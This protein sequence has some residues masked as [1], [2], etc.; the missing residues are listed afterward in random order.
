MRANKMEPESAHFWFQSLSLVVARTA[1]SY[2][3]PHGGLLHSPARRPPTFARMAASYV[4]IQRCP[5]LKF[6]TSLAPPWTAQ[7]LF[8]EFLCEWTN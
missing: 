1:A 4:L 3:R 8:E 5:A 7:I 6:E 2:I